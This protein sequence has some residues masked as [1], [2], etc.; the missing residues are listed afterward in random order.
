M[1][2][3]SGWQLGMEKQGPCHHLKLL[4][5]SFGKPILTMLIGHG[6]C[7]VDAGRG[8]E[9]FKGLGHKLGCVI[10]SK[11]LDAHV[12]VVR[13]DLDDHRQKSWKCQISCAE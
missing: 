7:K 11:R 3:Q 8:T 6:I 4:N 13:S 2:L 12:R 9:I 5:V 10:H 1:S